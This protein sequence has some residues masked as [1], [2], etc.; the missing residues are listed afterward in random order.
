MKIGDD[1]RGEGGKQRQSA[2]RIGEDDENVTEVVFLLKDG[3][4]ECWRCLANGAAS[5]TCKGPILDK[6]P[7][8]DG[9]VL[10]LMYPKTADNYFWLFEM[11]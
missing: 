3:Q 9:V 5:F 6:P 10:L 8:I 1:D 2:D 4:A 7:A 11:D